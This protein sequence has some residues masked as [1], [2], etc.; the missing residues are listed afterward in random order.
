MR[1]CISVLVMLVVSFVS[2]GAPKAAIEAQQRELA[3]LKNYL[4]NARDSLQYEI[5]E[6]WRLKQRFVEQREIDKE[7]LVSLRDNQ[8]RSF[9]DL[10]QAKEEFYARQRILEDE[11]KAVE[12]SV[13]KWEYVTASF[14]E[15][16]Q[17]ESESLD[18]AMPLDL[19]S[20]REKLEDIR[21]T[22]RS[23]RN[24]QSILPVILDYYENII[25][26]G[27][28]VSFSRKVVMPD[29][30]DAK[31]MTVVRFGNVFAYALSDDGTPHIIRQTGKL[32]AGKFAIQP[33]GAQELSTR[34]QE[35][36]PQWS[37]TAAIENKVVVDVMQN[38]N[39]GILISGKKVK[40]ST[41]FLT[42]LNSGGPVMIPLFALLFWALILIVAKLFQYRSKHKTNQAFYDN[43]L[44]LLNKKKHEEALSYARKNKGVVAKVV[45]TCLEHSKWNRSSAEKAVREILIDETP[46]LDK[47][48]ATLA[49]I[50]GAAPLLGL[51]GTVTGMIN[52]FEVITHYGTG[53][54]KILAGGIS[55]ALI[56]TQSGL[57]VAIPLLLVHNFLRNKSLHIQ[58]EMSKH[59]IRIL[60]RLWPE[61]EQ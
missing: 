61:T 56:T 6:R 42:W 12:S 27:Q 52:L 20:R 14:T 5:T 25:T 48:L 15:I 33:I 31:E 45:S 47:H 11:R 19:E 37:K 10:A 36:I 39:S 30:G 17:K 38:A 60:N 29:E 2:F 7:K 32:G 34:L 51:L 40:M 59:A 22:Y 43:V 24:P 55:E 46:Q 21:R 44:S 41:R 18:E 57:A 26:T 53:D 23:N 49:V 54:P 4:Q 58:N 28:S 1:V 35:Q 13:E 16:F 8:E 9:S 3:V 50:A